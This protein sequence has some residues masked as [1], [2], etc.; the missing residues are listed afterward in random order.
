MKIGLTTSVVVHGALLAFGLLTLSAPAPLEVVNA[1]SFP[2]EIVPISELSQIQQG[3]K[4]APMKETAAPKPTIRPDIVADAKTVGENSIDTNEPPT[5]EPTPKPVKATDVPPPQPK[6]VDKPIPKPDVAEAKPVPTPATEVAPVPAPEQKVQPEPVKE[7]VVKP[8]PAKPPEPAPK[9]EPVKEKPAPKEVTPDAVAEAIQAEPT[10]VKEDKPVEKPQPDT[11]ADSSDAVKLPDSAPSPEAKPKPPQ[12]QTA[13][14]TERKESNVPVQE[15]SAN[16]QSSEKE[17]NAADIEALLNK[18]KASG[19]GAKRST[20]TVSTGGDK[21][22]G[23]SKLSQTEMDALRGQVQK[24]WNVPA[25]AVDGDSLRVSVKFKLTP[26]GELDGSPEIISGGGANG[27]E[28]AAAESAR[29][30][31]SRCAPYNLP[32][33]KYDAWAD[34]IVNFDPSEM[35]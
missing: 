29:R 15:A 3:D 4:K 22:T 1:E 28:R 12:A 18:Q 34:V 32:A 6:P 30:A 21:T 35:F 27:V 9:P 24:C 20:K 31:V 26:A 13:K 11:A 23:G 8:A 7:A 33:D 14:T 5:P 17:F 2:V 19:G 25:G 16:P 10:P